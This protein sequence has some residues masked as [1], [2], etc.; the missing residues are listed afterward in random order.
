MVLHPLAEPCL[1]LTGLSGSGGS[2]KLRCAFALVA[3]AFLLKTSK[4]QRPRDTQIKGLEA[5]EL[6]IDVYTYSHI[7]IYD[8]LM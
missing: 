4:A 6:C 7:G 3:C 1:I 5:F 8:L 2:S